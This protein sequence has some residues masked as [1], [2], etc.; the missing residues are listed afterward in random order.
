MKKSHSRKV[1]LFFLVL[2]FVSITVGCGSS[3]PNIAGLWEADFWNGAYI[4]FTADLKFFVYEDKNA[5]ENNDHY[6]DGAYRFFEQNS[7][8]CFSA[9]NT[10]HYL[11]AD[12]LVDESGDPLKRWAAAIEYDGDDHI[13][14]IKDDSCLADERWVYI[15]EEMNLDKLNLRRVE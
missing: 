12:S 8:D 3:T 2:L 1:L 15:D 13:I 7:R 14:L 4:K 10:I 5:A 9:I 11:I 6:E